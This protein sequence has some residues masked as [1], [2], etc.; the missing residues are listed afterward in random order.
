MATML[1]MLMPV[2]ETVRTVSM[3]G[4]TPHFCRRLF[5]VHQSSSLAER[6]PSQTVQA[7]IGGWYRREKGIATYT[8]TC[9]TLKSWEHT[10][11]I[12]I[13]FRNKTRYDKARAPYIAIPCPQRSTTL[14]SLVTYLTD[15]VEPWPDSLPEGL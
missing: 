3:E 6:F 15:I 14:T 7:S 1:M 10:S 9:K 5:R 11:L 8:D 12:F 4:R 13:E 2:K